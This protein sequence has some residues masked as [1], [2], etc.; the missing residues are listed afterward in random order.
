MSVHN[1][2]NQLPSRVFVLGAWGGLLASTLILLVSYLWQLWALEQYRYFPALLLA[3]GLLFYGRWDRTLR[4]PVRWPEWMMLIGGA[5]AIVFGAFYWS[6]WLGCLG[7]IL[8]FGAFLSCCNTPSSWGLLELWPASW[9]LLRLPLNFDFQLTAWLQTV[10]ARISSHLLDRLEIPHRLTGNVFHLT[11]GKLFVETACS[12]IQSLFSLLFCAVLWVVWQ[13]RSVVLLPLYAAI[14]I[15]WAGVMNILRVT[16]IAIGQEWWHVDLAHG[17]AHEVLG[18]LCL[19]IA[20][21]LLISTDRIF[22]VVFYPVP[23][24]PHAIRATNPI[25]NVWNWLLSNMG[26]SN[27]QSDGKRSKSTII[28]VA[29]SWALPVA[30]LIIPIVLVPQLVFGYVHWTSIPEYQKT[31]YWRPSADLLAKIPGLEVLEHTTTNDSSNPAL[32]V[33]S[34]GWVCRFNGMVTRV[35]ASQHA[36]VHDLCKCYSANGWRIQARTLVE[37]KRT[38]GRGVWD[39]VEASFVNTD[40]VFGELFFST[41]DRQAR[42]VRLKGWELSDFVL[43]RVDRGDQPQQSGFDGQ[44]VNIQLWTTSETPF[45]EPQREVLRELH[46]QVRELIQSD[47]AGAH[48]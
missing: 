39:V 5:L 12:G 48:N 46:R 3:V 8:L 19:G 42:A 16:T 35:L 9:M 11:E 30:G 22:R 17:W 37:A 23:V 20:I 40:T 15:F 34:D 45:V 31:E 38:D 26:E 41:I 25:V 2:E 47:L 1:D 27:Q 14:G 28:G 32:G 44:N 33:H 6:P 36:E 29:T 18:Y 7:F 43:Q 13:R 4:L 10:T 24:D 21:A